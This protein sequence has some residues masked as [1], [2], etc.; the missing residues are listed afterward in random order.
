M[1]KYCL[2]KNSKLLQGQS[3][4]TIKRKLSILLPAL[5]YFHLLFQANLLTLLKSNPSADFV[6]QSILNLNTYL[7]VS[8]QDDLL[9]PSGDTTDQKIL[10]IDW[11]R[12]F[13]TIAQ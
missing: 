6:Y 5:K 7:H 8:N 3:N 13:S 4:K 10:E 1:R 12:I 11:L 9:I 2:S